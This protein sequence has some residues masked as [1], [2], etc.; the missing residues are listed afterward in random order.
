[1]ATADREKVI[2]RVQL[3]FSD[4]PAANIEDLVAQAEEYFL[5]LTGRQTVPDRATHLWGDIAAEIKQHGLP[6]SG[7][8]NVSSIKRGDTTVNYSAGGVGNGLSGLDA[9][10]AL[11]KVA[12]IR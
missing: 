11:F 2:A 7:Q 4:L 5:G 1:M 9:R 8:Q 12:V 3:M 10:I 6:A